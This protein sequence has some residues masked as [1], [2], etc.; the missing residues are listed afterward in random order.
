MKILDRLK[1]PTFW[2]RSKLSEQENL[3]MESYLEAALHPVSP[4]PAF[5][6][7]LKTKLLQAPA[8][9]RKVNEVATIALLGL[10]GVLSG[11]IIF[12]TGIRAVVTILGALGVLR[13][14]RGQVKE[15]RAAPA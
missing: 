7:D 8:Y 9:E 11:L 15:K 5:M 4:Q 14:A 2:R 3:R 10:A 1:P 6:E 13:N 12:V